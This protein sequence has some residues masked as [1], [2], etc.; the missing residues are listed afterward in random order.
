[1]MIPLHSILAC[2]LLPLVVESFSIKPRAL[3]T[4]N[5]STESAIHAIPF[6]KEAALA[7]SSPL[8]LGSAHRLCLLFTGV[9]LG[10]ITSIP[11]AMMS[12]SGT[13][14]ALICANIGLCASALFCAAGIVGAVTKK[15]FFFKYACGLQLLALS[16]A[17]LF[18]FLRL[19]GLRGDS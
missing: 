14:L 17:L 1:M 13:R 10:M 15:S 8:L 19:V 4:Y 6:K 16:P 5:V 3:S 9:S 11:N 18:S 12:D 7:L 2:L